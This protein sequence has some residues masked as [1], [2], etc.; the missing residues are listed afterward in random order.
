M[1]RSGPAA[2]ALRGIRSV[3]PIRVAYPR[4][5]GIFRIDTVLRRQYQV[6]GL[7]ASG[8][9]AELSTGVEWWINGRCA[10]RSRPDEGFP[11]N[12]EPGSYTIVA[13]ADWGGRTI[14]S[15]QVRITVID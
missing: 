6:V 4:D 14:E 15:R 3:A 5:G 1:P 12:L 11:W 9:A 2:P 8:P 13:R 7:R 10:G